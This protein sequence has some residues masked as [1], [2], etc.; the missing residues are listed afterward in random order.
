MSF[1]QILKK[2]Q[3]VE[4]YEIY[5][6]LVKNK[7]KKKIWNGFDDDD[8]YDKLKKRMCESNMTKTNFLA[9]H[10][11]GISRL[12]SRFDIDG[13]NAKELKTFMKKLNNGVWIHR[14]PHYL[15]RC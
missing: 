4:A 5:S 3:D 2:I 10:S 6:W 15:Q 14:I 7:N 13:K 8:I 1:H 12:S 11:A 9:Y